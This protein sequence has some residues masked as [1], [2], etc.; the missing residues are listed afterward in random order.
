MGI[1]SATTY[2]QML[3]PAEN[4]HDTRMWFAN[5]PFFP[6]STHGCVP[7]DEYSVWPVSGLRVYEA[8][9]LLGEPG[10][11]FLKSRESCGK[12]NGNLY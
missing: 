1:K 10:W 6:T 4:H 7:G 2:V 11:E 8:W 5:V 9:A 12:I 3:L